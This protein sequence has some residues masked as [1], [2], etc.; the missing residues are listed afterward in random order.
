MNRGQDA[1]IGTKKRG[2][3]RTAADPSKGG[4]ERGRSRTAPAEIGSRAAAPPVQYRRP[5][6]SLG[7]IDPIGPPNPPDRYRRAIGSLRRTSRRAPS[8]RWDRSVGPQG[9]GS[10][11]RSDRSAEPLGSLRATDPIVPPDRW[12]RSAEPPR[13]VPPTSRVLRVLPPRFGSHLEIVLH[14]LRSGD[15][16]RDGREA[17]G[18]ERRPAATSSASLAS[19]WCRRRTIAPR[20]GCT[21]SSRPDRRPTSGSGRP[22]PRATCP[23]AMR[24]PRRS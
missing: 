3:G 2:R 12:D 15:E 11:D 14:R 18:G 7:P 4:K 17:R 19:G 21:R 5:I 22:Q 9:G 24:P 23:S 10:S 8:D 20:P 1:A 13:S 6:G 16:D